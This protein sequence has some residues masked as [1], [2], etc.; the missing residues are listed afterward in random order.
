[1]KAGDERK[2]HQAA[3]WR[4]GILFSRG[5]IKL[6]IG[7]EGISFSDIFPD[8]QRCLSGTDSVIQIMAFGFAPIDHC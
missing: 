7:S 6:G 1:M 2:A 8:I 5:R 3:V 4:L